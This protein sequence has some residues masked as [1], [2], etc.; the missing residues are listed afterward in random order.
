[1]W[2]FDRATTRR[3]V[4]WRAIRTRVLRLRRVRASFLFMSGSPIPRR[5]LLLRFLERYLLVGV[6][7][8]LAL[9]R[10][11]R[12]VGAD[13]RGDLSDLLLVGALDDDF[14]LHGR[15][16]PDTLGHL[17]HDRV[18]EAQG[19]IDRVARGLGPVANAHQQEL[20]LVTLGHA[21]DHAGDQRAHGTVH[22]VRFG[23]RRL[24][25]QRIA[26]LL[27]R[28]FAAEGALQRAKRA[29]DGNFSAGER[30]LDLGRHLDRTVSNARHSLLRQATMQMTSPPTPVARAL[31]SVITP[32]EVETMAIPRPFITRGMSS[33]LL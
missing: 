18:R 4:P 14:G 23:V 5:L 1:M 21:L 28:D 6:A 24:E 31:R 7:H 19:Q 13:F 9:V 11:R 12:S 15:F 33:L 2:Q 25:G 17:V 26:V 29:L 32:R 16:D 30:H 27:D 3:F 10:L 22:G 8:P 20:L